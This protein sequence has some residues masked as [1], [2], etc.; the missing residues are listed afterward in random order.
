LTLGTNDLRRFLFCL[1]SG[2]DGRE[3]GEGGCKNEKIDEVGGD[4]DDAKLLQNGGEDVREV[5]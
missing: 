1:F 2:D 3:G 5:G 4:A